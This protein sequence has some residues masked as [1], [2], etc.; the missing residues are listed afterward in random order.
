MRKIYLD[1]LNQHKLLDNYLDKLCQKH[2][3]C[4]QILVLFNYR[5]D[6]MNKRRY[7]S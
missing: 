2:L 3:P 7:Q 5:Q 6:V 4:N 1:R